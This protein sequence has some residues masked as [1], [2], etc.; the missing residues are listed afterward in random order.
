MRDA[1]HRVS[2]RIPNSAFRIRFTMQSWLEPLIKI[3][4]IVG[5]LQGAVA[6][7]VLVL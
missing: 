5:V 4:V 2:F 3:A 7:L 1:S 6:Y